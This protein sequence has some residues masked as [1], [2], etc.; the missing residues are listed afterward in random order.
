[1][2]KFFEDRPYLERKYHNPDEPFNPYNRRLYHGWECPVETGLSPEQ[3]KEDLK[4]LADDLKNES[5]SIYKARAVEYVLDNTRID[6]NEHDYFPLIYTWGREISET[7]VTLWEQEMF[8]VTEPQIKEQYDLFNESGAVNM[9]PD[10]DHVVP[11][12]KALME[13]GF[14]GI[15]ERIK[16]YK[17]YHVEN[18]IKK[19]Q[20]S[21]F[22]GMEIVYSAIIRFIERMY[23]FSLTK[24]HEKAKVVSTGLKNLSVGAPKTTYDAMLLIY[25][26]FIISDSIAYYQVRSLGSGLDNTLFPFYEKDLENDTFTREEIKE[27]LAYFF[28]QWSAI[29]N[30][31]GQPMYIAGTD[32]N[33][34]S[35]INKLTYDII[36]V[37]TDLGIYDPKIQIKY[38]PDFS[39]DLLSKILCNIRENKGAYVFC[40]EKGIKNAI[41]S[42]GGTEED[43]LECDIRGCYETGVKANEVVTET[44]YINALKAI[45]YVFT[46]G[47]DR[48]INKS[49]G[50]N[51]GEVAEFKSFDEFYKAFIE[52][53]DY[54]IDKAMEIENTY[55]KHLSEINPSLL[56]TGTIEGAL[57]KGVDAYQCGVKFNNSAILNC[58]FASAVDALMAV[59]YLVFEQ[60][61][62]TLKEL[63]TAIQNNWLGFEELQQKAKNSKYKYGNGEIETDNCAKRLSEHF[64]G[65]VAGKPNSRGGVYKANMHSAM[66]FIWQGEKTLASPDGRCDGEEESKN[67]G[68]SVGMDRSGVT[69]L[70]SSVT[71]LRPCSYNESFCIDVMLHPSAVLGDDG[72]VALKTLLDYYYLNDGMSVQF[73][74]FSAETL[75]EAQKNPEKYKNLQVRI[76]G[77]NVLWNDLM[78]I[79]QQSYIIRAENII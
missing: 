36:D 44:T 6:I 30:I 58:G 74:I 67:G 22:Q 4:K 53:W 41:L 59:K 40:C 28:M 76:C 18:G 55:E 72:L 20:L 61:L 33:G 49:V 9:W 75:K 8:T 52:Q 65:K 78:P 45:E 21:F 79:E 34:N 56:Y 51:T 57:Q 14:I 39:K 50:V 24:T 48:R 77:W 70:L 60:K 29:G 23:K 66:M 46:N 11:D 16:K 47:F 37:Y 26:Y 1:M 19:E 10:Y 2:K 62:V 73:N 43:A 68:P 15:Y 64:V 69:A 63:K 27:F 12:W 13:L 35:K 3:I 54:L 38:N 32:K 42:Y 71:K 7:T 5:H 17:A 31:M 25:L